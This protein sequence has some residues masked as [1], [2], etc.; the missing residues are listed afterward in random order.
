MKKPITI[1]LSSI[2]LI[3]LV[4]CLSVFSLLSLSDAKNALSFAERRADSVKAYYEVDSAAQK[5]IR[6]ISEELEKGGTLSEAGE[7]VVSQAT[8]AS[9]ESPGKAPDFSLS[10]T[11]TLL[12][13]F[14]MASGQSLRVE[15]AKNQSGLTVLSYYVYNSEEYE[16]D[17]R[18]PVWDGRTQ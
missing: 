10:E 2:I 12:L 13:D 16:I 17:N 8:S 18:L 6:D 14:S 4:L 5:L 9:A 3:L 1:G 11:G 15:L 7:T